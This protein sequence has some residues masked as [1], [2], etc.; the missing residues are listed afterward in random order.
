MS[1][2][3][4]IYYFFVILKYLIFLGLFALAGILTWEVILK[5]QS[6]DSSLK[7]SQVEI[8]ELPTITVC[9][10]PINNGSLVFGKDFTISKYSNF[11]VFNSD[12]IPRNLIIKEG[13]NPKEEV[14]LSIITTGFDGECYQF[15]STAEKVERGTY[16]VIAFDIRDSEIDLEAWKSIKVLISSKLNKLGALM[17]YWIDGEILE[18]NVE[19]D[20]TVEIGLRESEIIYLK[21]KSGCDPLEPSF[22]DCFFPLLYAK[23]FST[24]PEKC[25]PY[26]LP[27]LQYLN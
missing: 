23:D 27:G 26:S 2:V 12:K 17:I 4:H 25:L 7:H 21:E 22:Y 10:S 5:Y 19:R 6:Q 20:L 18:F 13:H 8:S 1:S 11:A 3:L 16:E 9:F 14:H 15:H 24:C